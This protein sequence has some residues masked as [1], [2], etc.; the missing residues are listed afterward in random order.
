M[1]DKNGIIKII[2]FGLCTKIQNSPLKR[3]RQCGT[4]GYIAPEVLNSFHYDEKCD[5]FSVGVIMFEM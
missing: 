2:D 5:M 3:R 4:P 1:K